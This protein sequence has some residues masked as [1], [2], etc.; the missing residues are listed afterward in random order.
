MIKVKRQWVVV[1]VL[2]IVVLSGWFF[3]QQALTK[4]VIDVAPV[5]FND[6]PGWRHV[7]NLR[8]SLVAFKRSCDQLMQQPPQNQVGS[9]LFPLTAADW[10]PACRAA[11][12]LKNPSNRAVKQ[13][14]KSY[15]QIYTIGLSTKKTGRFTAYYL[16]VIPARM[17]QE[18]GFSVPIYGRPQGMVS[19]NLKDFS[20]ELPRR[21][22]NAWVVGGTLLPIKVTRAQINAGA[23]KDRAPV[24]AWTDT[25]F[26]RLRLQT[27]GSGVLAFPGQAKK[28]VGYA[29]QTGL[30]GTLLGTSML[31]AG[32]LT[33]QTMSMSAIERWVTLHPTIARRLMEEN[34]SFVFFKWLSQGD[35]YGAQKA[36]LTPGY[37]LAVDARFT[38][39]GAPVWL[40]L[41]HVPPALKL[42]KTRMMIAQDTG[43]AIQ[44]VVRG[45]VYLGALPGAKKMAGAANYIGRWWVLLPKGSKIDQKK[46]NLIEIN[47]K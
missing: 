25:R 15:F 20:T 36:L 18:P 32:Y 1:L 29:G 3:Y 47:S 11:Y 43:G 30:P 8:H 34:Q 38:P 23:I 7:N 19:F 37:S 12:A 27:Q 26:N 39:L 13:F 10:Q 21:V 9:D 4:P 17:R 44:G 41:R 6:L 35:I 16:P 46:I 31:R 28:W 22:L 2:V 45:D 42:F 14:F 33:R 40:S 24:L 5:R